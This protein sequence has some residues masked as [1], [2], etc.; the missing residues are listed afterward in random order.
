MCVYSDEGGLRDGESVDPVFKPDFNLDLMRSYPYVGRALAFQRER[1]L[2]LGGF[3]SNYG[4]L[5][6]H[7]VLWRMVERDGIKV[8]EHI[9]EVMLESTLGL[10]QWLALPDVIE[11]NP[12]VLEAHL[13]RLGVAHEIRQG[14][15][16]LLNRV[17]YLH[18]VRPL[19]SIIIVCKDQLAAVQRCVET[20]LEKTAY[21]EY[22]LLLID[23][24]SESP[25]MLEP[26]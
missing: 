11:L 3:N 2:A 4:E 5:A 10:A 25:P 15:F 14:S 26:G 24:G 13:Q 1:F 19:V 23:N 17:D 12:Q 18:A 16:T 9:A 7:D 21:S 6:P 22:E 8:I 20:L